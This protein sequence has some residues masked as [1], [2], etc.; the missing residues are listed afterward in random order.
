TLLAPSRAGPR[1][2]T[3][4]RL[5]A[6]RPGPPGAGA[7]RAPE[8]PPRAPAGAPARAPRVSSPATGLRGGGWRAAGAGG[9]GREPAGDRRGAF[10]GLPFRRGRLVGAGGR[11]G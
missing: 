9:P 4:P 11:D 2:Q 6:G 8:G 1:P 5:S 3:Q 10:R 7:A